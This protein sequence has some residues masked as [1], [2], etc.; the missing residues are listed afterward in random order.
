MTLESGDQPLNVQELAS[1]TP[2]NI[3]KLL[4][5]PRL[6]L[7]SPNCLAKSTFVSGFL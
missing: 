7:G 5:V 2:N 1:I 4:Q 6:L 3:G